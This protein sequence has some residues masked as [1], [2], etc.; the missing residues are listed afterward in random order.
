MFWVFNHQQPNKNWSESLNSYN[1]LYAMGYDSY[2]L[3]A[4]LNRLI[5]FPAITLN[6]SGVLYLNRAHQIAR[7]LAWG[8]FRGGIAQLISQ[9]I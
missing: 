3:T 7:I 9:T 6:E 4:A 2:A 8:Q 5:L 1:R